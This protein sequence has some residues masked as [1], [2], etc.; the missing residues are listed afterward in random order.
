MIHSHWTAIVVL[1]VVIFLFDTLREKRSTPP[2]KQSGTA[3]FIKSR[4]TPGMPQ[5]TDRKSLSYT[6]QG[7]E[8]TQIIKT[9]NDGVGHY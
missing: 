6:D 1:A 5:H 8:E 2:T 3:C 7:E 9:S 4:G